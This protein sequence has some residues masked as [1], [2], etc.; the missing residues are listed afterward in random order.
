[1]DTLLKSFSTSI[2][3]NDWDGAFLLLN[4]SLSPAYA[5]SSGADAASVTRVSPFLHRFLD[6][7]IAYHNFTHANGPNKKRAV[8]EEVSYLR[9]RAPSVL[10]N[11]QFLLVFQARLALV[12]CHSCM[13]FAAPGQTLPVPSLDNLKALRALKA[14]LFSLIRPLTWMKNDDALDD[15]KPPADP[16]RD[17]NGVGILVEAAFHEIN[18]ILCLLELDKHINAFSFFESTMG[19]IE[20]RKAFKEFQTF[21]HSLA[22]EGAPPAPLAGAFLWSQGVFDK[23]SEK[24]SVVFDRVLKEDPPTKPSPQVLTQ[25]LEKNLTANAIPSNVVATFSILCW[26]DVELAQ[27]PGFTYLSD[28]TNSQKQKTLRTRTTLIPL[29]TRTLAQTENFQDSPDLKFELQDM[30]SAPSPI[31]ELSEKESW[32]PSP[33]AMMITPLPKPKPILPKHGRSVSAGVVGYSG[34]R[35]RSATSGNILTPVTD[36]LARSTSVDSSGSGGRSLSVN[37]PPLPSFDGGESLAD[38]QFQFVPSTVESSS[39][40]HIK[41]QISKTR[42]AGKKATDGGLAGVLVSSFTEEDGE[43][44]QKASARPAKTAHRSASSDTQAIRDVASIFSPL[45]SEN[46]PKVGAGLKRSEEKVVKITHH[47]IKQAGNFVVC[48]ILEEESDDR[49]GRLARRA[50]RRAETLSAEV[51]VLCK[52]IVVDVCEDALGNVWKV[53]L[54][55]GEEGVQDNAGDNAGEQK[56]SSEKAEGG[57]FGSWFKSLFFQREAD[58][59]GEYGTPNKKSRIGGREEPNK[60]SEKSRSFV[61]D[62][63]ASAEAFFFGGLA[64]GLGP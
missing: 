20:T 18:I 34:G 23:I 9:T 25:L 24:M 11:G 47:Y 4:Q 40:S 21:Y 54:D 51:N 58:D 43:P 42:R 59:D 27:K 5:A 31:Q 6:I 46:S 64:K 37:S 32:T 56:K 39:I 3:N 53:K 57:G 26:G 49:M 14:T 7:E 38:I 45:V 48:L 12:D 63:D 28:R 2:V 52:K 19:Y 50:L 10:S 35:I 22:P 44:A 17:R 15:S 16:K 13:M 8:Q 41:S 29:F 36:R 60:I 30:S 55:Q 1:M 61:E 62:A 33:A